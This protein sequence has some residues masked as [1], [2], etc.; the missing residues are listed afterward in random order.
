MGISVNLSNSGVCFFS[1]RRLEAG[2]KV[3]I[4]SRLWDSPRNAVVRWSNSIM[5]GLFRI[6]MSFE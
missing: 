1:H 2:Q 3:A 5:G 4:S 6:G